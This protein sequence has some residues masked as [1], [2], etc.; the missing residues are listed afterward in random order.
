MISMKEMTDRSSS[1]R[2][3]LMIGEKEIDIINTKMIKRRRLRIRIRIRPDIDLIREKTAP[4]IGIKITTEKMV[5]II[6]TESEKEA[7]SL[8]EK[9]GKNVMLKLEEE[10]KMHVMILRRRT[11]LQKIMSRR[12]KKAIDQIRKADKFRM[13][14][15]MIIQTK[16]NTTYHFQN[17]LQKKENS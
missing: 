7:E 3:Q 8:I 2:I 6:K 11:S 9:I 12:N 13:L 4:W 10:D 5:V 17:N 1:K 14:I 16:N 15:P